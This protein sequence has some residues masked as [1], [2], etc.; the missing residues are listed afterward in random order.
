MAHLPLQEPG[1]RVNL[2]FNRMGFCPTAGTRRWLGVV[3][4][5]PTAPANSTFL[6][7]PNLPLALQSCHLVPWVALAGGGTELSA[8]HHPPATSQAAPAHA[9]SPGKGSALTTL[10]RPG[11]IQPL[12]IYGVFVIETKRASVC[13]H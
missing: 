8:L 10:Q 13:P 9:P 11:T 2:L 7:N 6:G 4:F 1:A 5:H 12:G 3:L